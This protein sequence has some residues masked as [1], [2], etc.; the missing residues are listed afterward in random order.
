MTKGWFFLSRPAFHSV[1]ILPFLL[2]SILSWRI[3]GSFDWAVF[4]W[5][6]TAVILIMLATYLNGECYD[7]VE[8]T[9]SGKLKKSAFAGGS[10]IIQKGIVPRQHV[11]IGAYITISMAGLIG[12]IL[13]FYYKTGPWI[14]PLGIIGII[15]GFFY[16]K[17]PIRWVSK[18]VGEL[19][20]GFCYGWL[21]VAT[22]C[23][24]QSGT[25]DSIINWISIPIAC[26]IVNVILIN[27][28]PDYS[29]DLI[30]NKT[31]LL[32]R[33]GKKKGANLY[34]ALTMVAWIAYGLSV[35]QGFPLV[36][37]IYY[38]PV[39]VIS[40]I[41]IIMMFMKKY[42]SRKI[43]EIICGLTIV[44]NLGTSLSYILAVW[45]GNF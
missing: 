16:S 32:V 21:P 19:L 36:T 25:I 41:L 45:K 6:L 33:I 17:P 14:I 38:L 8:D 23:Y 4:A 26:S 24:I 42:L 43:L 10:Q 12:L 30:A 1:G 37:L 9:L 29:A 22:A 7:V 34:I 39:F 40:L 11:K 35:K 27:S 15:A 20:I 3:Y 2:G 28:F 18:G 31:N 44:V 5:G 13:L